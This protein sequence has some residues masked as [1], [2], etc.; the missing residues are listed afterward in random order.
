MR[1]TV[2][3]ALV[4]LLL[5][6]FLVGAFYASGAHLIFDDLDRCLDAGG[7]WDRETETCVGA[8]W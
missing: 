2:R 7:G 8:A 1:K 5:I 3:M 4:I 6:T